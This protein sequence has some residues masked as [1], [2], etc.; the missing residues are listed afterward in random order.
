MGGLLSQ[1]S[2]KFKVWRFSDLAEEIITQPKNGEFQDLPNAI[3]IPRM[4]SLK[5]VFEKTELHSNG[6]NYFQVVLKPEVV[7]N[8]YAAQYLS[9]PIGIHSLQL[10]AQG[11]LVKTLDMSSLGECSIP[12]PLLQEQAAI[13]EINS[14][15]DQLSSEIQLIKN[16]LT[17]KPLSKE[18]DPQIDG[19]LELFGKQTKADRVRSLIR[20][21]ENKAIEFKETYSWCLQKKQKEKYVETSALKTIVAFLNSAGGHLIIG[22]SDGMQL[23][24][25]DSEIGKLHKNSQDKFLRAVKNNLKERI[26]EPFYPFF[27]NEII[28]LEGKRILVFECKPSDTP[29]YLDTKDFYVRTNPASDKLEGPKLVDYVTNH[30]SK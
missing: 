24:G 28:E 15:L 5:T 12:L 14:K 30:F 9:S 8:E 29:C 20:K 26:G 2:A 1:Y 22:V 6:Q 13:L 16:E 18:F 11:T 27:D 3:Y 21:G 23:T 7:L 4:L 17:L 19:M 25:V 10:M